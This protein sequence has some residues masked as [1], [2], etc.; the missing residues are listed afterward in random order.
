MRSYRLR[1]D[2]RRA[3]IN[4]YAF[5][6]GIDPHG[7]GAPEQGF[8]VSYN[9]ARDDVPDTYAFHVVVSHERVKALLREAFKLLPEMV[10]GI[11]EIGSRDAYRATDVFVGE[12]P[13]T[14]EEFLETWEEYE[15]FLLEDG[16]IGA[17][18]NSEDPFIEVFLD[19][20]KGVSIH[21]PLHQR[22]DVEQM[23]RGFNLDEVPQTWLGSDIDDRRFGEGAEIRQVLD[24]ND[25]YAPDVDEL[26]LELRHAWN[27]SLNIDPERNED[28]EGRLLGVTL[29]HVVVI[30]ESADDEGASGA[31]ITIWATAESPNELGDLVE[32]VMHTYPQ[33]QLTDVYSMDRVAYD[34]R[35]EELADLPPRLT[36]RKVHAVEVE[37]WETMPA[38]EEERTE[39]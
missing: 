1:T 2:L 11:V 22:D 19:Q 9:Q 5:P 28:E 4:G 17:G 18:A 32:D 16:T 30:G 38:S 36:E 7:L 34:D 24:L 21:V 37:P 26:L 31:Y 6:L 14:R 29:W 39:P 25:D 13:V 15:P 33:W 10:Y 3:S 20:W 8:T 12:D 35:P 27:L 23:L